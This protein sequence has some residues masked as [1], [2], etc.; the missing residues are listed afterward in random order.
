MNLSKKKKKKKKKDLYELKYI[1]A[2][3]LDEQSNNFQRQI[4][5][6]DIQ[7]NNIENAKRC[8]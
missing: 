2:A 5:S 7:I 4:A 8:I 1:L 3:I 6:L